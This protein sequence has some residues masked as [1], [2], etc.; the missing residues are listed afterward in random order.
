MKLSNYSGVSS[1][2]IPFFQFL[3]LIKS[4][5]IKECIPLA[6]LCQEYFLF[7]DSMVPGVLVGGV[8]DIDGVAVNAA[9]HVLYRVDRITDDHLGS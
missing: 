2:G 9:S 1:N 4:E 6:L 3:L 7:L 8:K 5:N